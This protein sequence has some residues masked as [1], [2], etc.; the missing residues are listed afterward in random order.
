MK[1]LIENEH[2]AKTVYSAGA[3][4]YTFQLTVSSV[5]RRAPRETERSFGSFCVAFV[6]IILVTFEY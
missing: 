1:E 4:Q 2:R 3:Y 6:H 5:F